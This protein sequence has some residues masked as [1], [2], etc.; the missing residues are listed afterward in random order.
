M[1][2]AQDAFVAAQPSLPTPKLIFVDE[3]GVDI[4]MGRNEGW[5]P[6]GKRPVLERP[7]KGKR[8]SLIGAIMAGGGGALRIEQD[9]VDGQTFV[10]YLNED[11]G[12]TLNAGDIVIMDRP[13][14]HRVAG[15][16]E[17]VEGRGATIIYLP[18]YS[19]ELN[20]IEMAWSWLKRRLRKAPPRRIGDLIRRVRELWSTITA[21]LC[22]AWV[23]RSGYSDST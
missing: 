1:I 13:K 21:T 2:A 17:A 20:P 6:V 22:S 7:V 9:N 14:I 12:P 4:A 15:V 8:V 5:A 16:R 18:A 10:R 19:P 23:R 3:A 11:L